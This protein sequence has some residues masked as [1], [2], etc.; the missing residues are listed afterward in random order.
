[1][2]K[3]KAIYGCVIVKGKEYSDDEIRKL[4]GKNVKGWRYGGDQSN[5]E[6]NIC[7]VFKSGDSIEYGWPDSNA[8]EEC[9]ACIERFDPSPF[10][11]ATQIL[12]EKNFAK[13]LP[14][15]AAKLKE[16]GFRQQ[17][18]KSSILNFYHKNPSVCFT[19]ERIDGQLRFMCYGNILCAGPM[20]EQQLL[21]ALEKFTRARKPM[22]ALKHKEATQ[23]ELEEAFNLV[24][25]NKHWKNPINKTIKDPGREMQGLIVE[26]VAHY[27][28][29]FPEIST[30]PGGK[31]NVRAAGYYS[32]IGA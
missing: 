14:N 5:E 10:A 1:M 9:L 7:I 27:T 4:V 26:A 30:L 31:I 24:K 19:F 22:K 29:S 15:F 3:I 8:L 28:G 11:K 21:N 25:N 23:E 20:T 2:S 6:S 13:L 16:L 17:A 18:D 32:T 12:S